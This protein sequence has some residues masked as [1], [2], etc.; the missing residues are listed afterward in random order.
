MLGARI[1]FA[2]HIHSRLGIPAK[3][4]V[5]PVPGLPGSRVHPLSGVPGSRVHL[6][7][8]FSPVPVYIRAPGIVLD[9]F[10][11]V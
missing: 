2:V 3:I 5:Y 9:I 7:L 8:G 1:Y 6:V 10:E 4:R 11:K